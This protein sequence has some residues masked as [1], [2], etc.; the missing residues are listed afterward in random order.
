M[1]HRHDEI[2]WF[3]YVSLTA[4]YPSPSLTHTRTHPFTLA[5]H[6][7]TMSSADTRN[8]EARLDSER[9]R[10]LDSHLSALAPKHLD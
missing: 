4:P 8:A 1:F 9:I 3:F 5:H 6:S 10:N 2:K 7:S